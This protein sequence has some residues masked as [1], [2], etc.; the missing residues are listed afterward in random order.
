MGRNKMC[1]TATGEGEGRKWGG[2]LLRPR[3][4]LIQ[5]RYRLRIS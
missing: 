4:C 1:G 2:N 5:Y 3:F